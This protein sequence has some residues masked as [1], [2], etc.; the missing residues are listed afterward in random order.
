MSVCRNCLELFKHS[1]RVQPKL[2]DVSQ[3]AV[4]SQLSFIVFTTSVAGM[5]LNSDVTL[6]NTICLICF[7][8]WFPDFFNKILGILDVMY[9]IVLLQLKCTMY[10]LI[11]RLLTKAG[12]FFVYL[13]ES[14]KACSGFPRVKLIMYCSDDGLFFLLLLQY[15]QSSYYFIIFFFFWQLLVESSFSFASLQLCY[16]EIIIY[17]CIIDI[18]CI[19][20]CIIFSTFL[21]LSVGWCCLVSS[22]LKWLKVNVLVMKNKFFLVELSSLHPLVIFKWVI[23]FS[24]IIVKDLTGQEA[25]FIKC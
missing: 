7:H 16:F 18:I 2:R 22:C 21:Y 14:I 1:Q 4:L 15:R 3:G 10:S 20:I 11:Q 5:H 23:G 8:F 19:C 12:F 6:Q 9:L 13:R 25:C 17:L 24:S